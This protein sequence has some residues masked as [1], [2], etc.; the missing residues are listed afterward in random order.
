[1]SEVIQLSAQR[2]AMED[3]LRVPVSGEAFV[4]T[5]DK[6]DGAPPIARGVTLM[7]R[8]QVEALAA[9]RQRLLG[10]LDRPPWPVGEPSAAA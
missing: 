2:V 1:M 3:D 7:A 10:G 9:R 4:L 5:L 6:A 8:E